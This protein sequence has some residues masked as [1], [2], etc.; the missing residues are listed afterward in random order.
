MTELFKHYTYCKE[1]KTM[2]CKEDHDGKTYE[3]WLE[4]KDVDKNFICKHDYRI[5]WYRG[6][7]TPSQGTEKYTRRGRCLECGT[8]I[9]GEFSLTWAKYQPPDS[10]NYTCDTENREFDYPS[11]TLN[12]TVP[13]TWGSGGAFTPSNS[14]MDYWNIDD[15]DESVEG[16]VDPSEMFTGFIRDGDDTL[17][18]VNCDRNYIRDDGMTGA[19]VNKFYC[20]TCISE[21]CERAGID[22]VENTHITNDNYSA[23]DFF[24]KF[25]TLHWFESILTRDRE[26]QDNAESMYNINDNYLHDLT[27]AGSGFNSDDNYLH[28]MHCNTPM[29]RVRSRY[30]FKIM[31][32]LD[33]EHTDTPHH[34]WDII[35]QLQICEDCFDN[36]N[37]DDIESNTLSPDA[38]YGAEQIVDC[39]NLGLQSDLDVETNYTRWIDGRLSND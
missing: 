27:S 34:G 26:F 3:E 25:K 32:A 30:I 15:D 31:N 8:Q 36:H 20:R 22:F 18:C 14:N 13:P 9:L 38:L 7:L 21:S 29:I 10:D 12:V 19:S 16:E 5:R 35:D 1:H 28:C 17:Q 2:E 11:Q 37:Y 6:S 33:H 24:G 23:C 4:N 39:Q